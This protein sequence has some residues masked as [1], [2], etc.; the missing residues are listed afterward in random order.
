M[1]LVPSVVQVVT[2]AWPGQHCGFL[3]PSRPSQS[4]AMH[5]LRGWPVLG[6]GKRLAFV[7]SGVALVIVLA[8]LALRLAH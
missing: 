5:P 6:P 7:V 2:S 1:R 3:L 8:I 4:P